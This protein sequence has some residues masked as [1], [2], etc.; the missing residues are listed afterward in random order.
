ML[1]R[2]LGPDGHLLAYEDDPVTRRMLRHNLAANRV[3][4]VTVMQR[5]LGRGRFRTPQDGIAART[6]DTV[7]RDA[8]SVDELASRTPRLAQGE[9][10]RGRACRPRR[11][12]RIALAP[13]PMPASLRPRQAGDAD[14]P[15]FCGSYGYRAWHV[16]TPYFHRRQLQLPHRR[17]LCGGR[18]RRACSPFRK[19]SRRAWRWNPCDPGDR[20]PSAWRIFSP[21]SRVFD[22]PLEPRTTPDWITR[23]IRTRAALMRRSLRGPRPRR[24]PLRASA[25]MMAAPGW[26][27]RR[28]AVAWG[29][30]DRGRGPRDCRDVCGSGTISGSFRRHF[31]GTAFRR[32]RAR[33]R[34]RV[35]AVVHFGR[36]A[37][38]CRVDT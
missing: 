38:R 15:E 2:V 16:D 29:P 1:G 34:S 37:Q 3:Q 7:L 11:R 35:R 21:E 32:L 18:R 33:F 19:R 31:E 28:R 17:H 27:R 36:A 26:A 14:M 23:S 25:T 8:D 10:R 6:V 9:C 12:E 22:I 24:R 5:R 30:F 20:I 4:N 13:A